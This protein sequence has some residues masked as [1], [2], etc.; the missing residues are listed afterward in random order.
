MLTRYYNGDEV[1]TQS[2][3]SAKPPELDR[4]AN[5]FARALV[6]QDNFVVATMGSSVTRGVG[7]CQADNYPNQLENL[8]GPLLNQANVTLEI[9]NSSL[10]GRCGDTSRN[11]IWCM[12]TLAGP[13]PDVLHYSWTYF[14]TNPT[15]RAQTHE[16]FLRWSLLQ[17]GAPIPQILSANAC[18]KATEAEHAMMRQYASYG[19]GRLCMTR[20]IAAQGWPGKVWGEV[21]DGLHNTTRAGM[22]ADTSDARRDSLGVVFRNWHPGPLL[23]QTTADTLAYSY[24]EALLIAINKIRAT[25][26]PYAVWP[27]ERPSLSASDLPEIAHCND[28]WCQSDALPACLT[29]SHPTFGEST[30][31]T[32]EGKDSHWSIQRLGGSEP[33]PEQSLNLKRCEFDYQCGGLVPSDDGNNAIRFQLPAMRT[34]LVAVCCQAKDCGEQLRDA[35]WRYA[36]NGIAIEPTEQTFPERKCLLIQSSADEQTLERGSHELTILAPAGRRVPPL[37]HILSR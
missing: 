8:L 13:A 17:P 22:A 2:W 37:T 11:Q 29:F 7:N 15:L 6:W 4:L 36:L 20:G 24:T 32:L 1:M 21:G 3:L 35:S 9:R 27:K 14:D 18:T 10:D 25:N 16:R 34:G 31:K 28:V 26:N 23:F 5:K 19:A 33:Y 12:P 30:I